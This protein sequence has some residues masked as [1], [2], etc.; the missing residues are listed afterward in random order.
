VI[1][2]F[3]SEGTEDIGFALESSKLTSSQLADFRFIRALKLFIGNDEHLPDSTYAILLLSH[4]KSRF[5]LLLDKWA[6]L[7]PKLHEAISFVSKIEEKRYLGISLNDSLDILEKKKFMLQMQEYEEGI[8]AK[9]RYEEYL[10]QYGLLLNLYQPHSYS[11]NDRLRFGPSDRK[12]R[13]CRYC[14]KRM[15]ETTFRNVS[16]TISRS[17]GNI[18]FITNDECDNCNAHFGTGIE[19]EFLKYVSVFRTLAAIYEGHPFYTTQTDTFR[20]SVDE[21]TNN[22]GFSILDLSKAKITSSDSEAEISVDGGYIN[23]HD[24]YRALVKFVI[25]MLPDEQ[26]PLFKETI[27]WVNGE[28]NIIRLPNIKK[29]IYNE[30]ER[31]PFMNMFFR[32]ENTNEYPYL[33]VDF[34]VNHLEFVYVVPGCSKDESA[35][36]DNIL[37]E[38]LKLKKDSYQWRNVKMNLPQ[39][40]HMMFRVT[41]YMKHTN[42]TKCNP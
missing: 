24:V 33:V 34:H 14:G 26:L 25:G 41:Y 31:H 40:R 7:F 30:P 17:L 29:A 21:E 11:Y 28:N 39:P 6:D 13:V 3:T 36:S 32:K 42:D 19:Q 27:K 37:D 5:L 2:F 22:I 1:H 20:L 12:L 4:I 38:F 35:F 9:Q 10:N 16:H 18:S 23:F 15:P 8:P